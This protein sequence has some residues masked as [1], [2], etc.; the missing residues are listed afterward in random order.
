MAGV[1]GVSRGLLPCGVSEG[2]REVVLVVVVRLVGRSLVA[3][4]VATGRPPR[5]HGRRAGRRER[6]KDGEAG[7]GPA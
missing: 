6:E 7:A 2:V 3:G 1:G 5:C 4:V